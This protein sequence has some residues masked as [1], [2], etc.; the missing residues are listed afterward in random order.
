MLTATAPEIATPAFDGWL[1]AAEPP[2]P[3]AGAPASCVSCPT[4]PL[5]E[6]S[7]LLTSVLGKVGVLV[8]GVALPW[9]PGSL[10]ADVSVPVPPAPP[11]PPAPAM[12]MPP[13]PH[14]LKLLKAAEDSPALA[15]AVANGFNHPPSF[16]PWW[17]DELACEAF[18]ASKAARAAA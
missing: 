4:W 13:A 17:R 3:D 11:E 14:L 16:F 6:S 15:S 2:A 5:T 1:L 10:M 8:P 18:I 12:L 9:L 7:T